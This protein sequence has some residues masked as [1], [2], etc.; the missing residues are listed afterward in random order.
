MPAIQEAVFIGGLAR[1]VHMYIEVTCRAV[2]RGARGGAHAGRGARE[3][4]NL[5]WLYCKM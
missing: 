5:Q 1:L 4:S 3:M 2:Q